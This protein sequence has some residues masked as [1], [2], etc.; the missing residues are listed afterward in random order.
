MQTEFY[1]TDQVAEILGLSVVTIRNYFRD[2]RIKGV[3]IGPAIAVPAAEVERLKK[4]ARRPSHISWKT[5]EG[6]V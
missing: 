6:E 2:G 3:K 5:E 1:S 4:L